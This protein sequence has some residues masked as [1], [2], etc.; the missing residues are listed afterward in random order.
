MPEQKRAHEHLR[1]ARA[2]HH[3]DRQIHRDSAIHCRCSHRIT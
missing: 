3:Y 2:T 1:M